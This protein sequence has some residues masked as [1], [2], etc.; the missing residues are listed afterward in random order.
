MERVRNA[1]DSDWQEIKYAYSLQPEPR[2]H[3]V[4]IT[5]SVGPSCKDNDNG[6]KNVGQ[7]M[8]LPSFNLNRVYLDP[9]NMLNAKVQKEEENSSSYDVRLGGFTS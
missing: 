3:D 1:L 6:I 4:V 7:K 5:V 8:N 2:S 9:L